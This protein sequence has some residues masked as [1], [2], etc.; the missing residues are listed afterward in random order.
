MTEQTDTQLVKEDTKSK[1]DLNDTGDA[2]L[3]DGK[4]AAPVKND[5]FDARKAI[6]KK[7]REVREV[8]VAADVEAH[9]DIDEQTRAMNEAMDKGTSANE[10]LRESHQDTE[11]DE[12]STEADRRA[13]LNKRREDEA[14]L[15]A[16]ATDPYADLPERVNVTV[17]GQSFEVPKEDVVEAG[18]IKA[19]QLERAASMRMQD[20]AKR[21]A[22]LAAERAALEAERK[23]WLEQRASA[24]ASPAPAP[25]VAPGAAPTPTGGAGTSDDV[26]AK[27]EKL[28]KDLYSGDPKLAAAAIEQIVSASQVKVT[29]PQELARQAAE[30]LKQQETAAPAPAKQPEA[31]QPVDPELRELN[32]YM[33]EKFKD[34]LDDPEQKRI[35]LQKFEELKADPANKYR[36]L[37]DLGRV[38]GRY[39]QEH[40]H[41]RQDVVERKQSLPPATAA[42]AVS[43]APAEPERPTGSSIVARMR[44]ARGQL[45]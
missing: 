6:F 34:V 40:R 19:Y 24:G 25:G 26:K 44:K 13:A 29:D 35:A 8:G 45:D 18:G 43:A 12:R 38:A 15:N 27:A 32:D 10:L 30:L 11:R 9:A 5:P 31:K 33:V 28:A 7:H 41:P 22:E 39:A 20:A 1:V 17:N 16:Q 14:R 21:E 23:A 2:V 4:G 3:D 42:T 37:I 36:R